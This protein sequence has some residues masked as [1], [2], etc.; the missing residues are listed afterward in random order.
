MHDSELVIEFECQSY[1]NPKVE[2]KASELLEKYKSL[3]KSIK[4]DDKPEVLV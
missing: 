4:E 2:E 1:T 3:M